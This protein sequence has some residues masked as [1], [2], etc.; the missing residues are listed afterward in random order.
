M[1]FA[2]SC[3]CAA[4]LVWRAARGILCLTSLMYL[5]GTYIVRIEFSDHAVG[6]TWQRIDRS[7]TSGLL[8]DQV[9]R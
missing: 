3:R 6:F 4:L 7:R 2:G 8:Q 1:G 9:A 5:P